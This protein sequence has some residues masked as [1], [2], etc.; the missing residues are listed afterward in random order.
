MIRSACSPPLRRF[1]AG[2]VACAV[3]A[4]CFVACVQ[5]QP[6]VPPPEPG[7]AAR[8]P[9]WV[10]VTTR[11]SARYL[12][13]SAAFRGDTLVGRAADAGETAAAALVRVPAANIAH[14]EVRV[15]SLTGSAGMAAAILAG[16]AAF[17]WAVGHATTL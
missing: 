13:E 12:L 4:L 3:C 11:D 17:A 14:L 7:A 16:V 10:R 8:L 9:R 1:L 5:W 6:V 15:P 2:S